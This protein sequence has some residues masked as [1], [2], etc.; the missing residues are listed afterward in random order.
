MIGCN[1]QNDN[2]NAVNSTDKN[3][4]IQT[5]VAAKQTQSCTLALNKSSSPSIRNFSQKVLGKYKAMETDLIAIAYKLNLA[6]TD[7]TSIG[8]E[9]LNDLNELNGYSFDSAY[10]RSTAKSQMNALSLFENEINNGNNTYV[11]YYFV[12]KYI[13]DVRSLYFEAD[14]ISRVLN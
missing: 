4:L 9:S 8:N 2:P 5:Y 10:I 1:K 14:S 13:D 3:F 12:N 6:L 11:R 7:T